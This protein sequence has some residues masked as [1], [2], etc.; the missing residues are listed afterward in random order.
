MINALKLVSLNRGYDPRDFTLIAFGGGGGMH[1]NALAAELQVGQVIIPAESAVFSA[2]G[3][4]MSDLRRDYFK[5][6]LCDLDENAPARLRDAFAAL[7][8]QAR[9]EFAQAGLDESALKFVRFARFRYRNQEHSTEVV[10]PE[11]GVTLD[12]LA[13]IRERFEV[14][15]EREYTYRLTTVVEVVPAA[16]F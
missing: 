4:V 7:E 8:E 9:A 6:F 13:E 5:T 14:N 2:W 15:Y 11:E 3:M 12:N 10:L 1:A 16:V